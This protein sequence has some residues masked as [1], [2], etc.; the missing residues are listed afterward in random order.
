MYNKAKPELGEGGGG[1][2]GGGLGMNGGKL[3][4]LLL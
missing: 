1:G 4:L 3:V 2:G